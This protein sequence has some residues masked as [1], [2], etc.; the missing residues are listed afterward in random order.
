[1]TRHTLELRWQLHVITIYLPE[2]LIVTN[3][4][5]NSHTFEQFV[6]S[7]V[8]IL[9]RMTDFGRFGLCAEA[10]PHISGS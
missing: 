6:Y 2:Y 4:Q 3:R 5:L 10:D 1:M 9:C 7:A 8:E